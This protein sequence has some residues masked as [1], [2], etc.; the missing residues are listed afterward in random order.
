M[1]SLGHTCRAFID[2]GRYELV[3]RAT[4]CV[5][6]CRAARDPRPHCTCN[7]KSLTTNFGSAV[8]AGDGAG[9]NLNRGTN[10]PTASDQKCQPITNGVIKCNDADREKR[11]HSGEE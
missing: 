5:S 9:S 3:D 10:R 1:C 2:T 6:L 11:R 7:C 8:V 4:L